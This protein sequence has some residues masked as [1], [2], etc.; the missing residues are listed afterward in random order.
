MADSELVDLPD[1]PTPALTDIFYIVT[2]PG[3]TPADGK[4]TLSAVGAVLPAKPNLA[5]I[6]AFGG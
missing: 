1:V 4:V 6:Y 2:D 3:G 5:T